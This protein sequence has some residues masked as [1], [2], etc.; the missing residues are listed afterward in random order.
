[1]IDKNLNKKQTN[2]QKF[3]SFRGGN[4]MYTCMSTNKCD[5]WKLFQEWG[6]GDKGEWWR[7]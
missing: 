3:P 2:K 7:G 1:V 5:P 6:Q 4:T